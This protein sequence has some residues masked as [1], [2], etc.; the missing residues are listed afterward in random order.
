M[1]RARRQTEVFADL[2]QRALRNLI[3][4]VSYVNKEQ[5]NRRIDVSPR[6]VRSGVSPPFVHTSMGTAGLEV[7]RVAMLLNAQ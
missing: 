1:R 4:F 2:K 5:A 7:Y 3:R 6:G